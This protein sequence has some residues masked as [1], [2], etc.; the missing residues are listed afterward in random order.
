[1]ICYEKYEYESMHDRFMFWWNVYVLWFMEFYA[2]FMIWDC[3]CSM[4]QTNFMTM[5][6]TLSAIPY[7]YKQSVINQNVA[8]IVNYLL[9]SLAPSQASQKLS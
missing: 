2:T 7:F 1:M 5:V 6:F 3:I 8:V 9:A 4:F